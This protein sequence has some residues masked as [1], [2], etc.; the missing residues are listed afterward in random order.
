MKSFR[1]LETLDISRKEFLALCVL[2]S[3][4]FAGILLK[5]FL[6]SHIGSEDIK[7]LRQDPQETRL[8][9]DVNSA[10]WYEL[11][12]LPKIGEKRARAIVEYREKYGPFGSPE[13]L[14]KVKGMSPGVL[15]EIKG[16]LRVD[17]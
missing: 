17:R 16:Y 6:D 14:L 4:L 8:Q 10:G 13:D 7:M 5:Y 2:F 1:V 9:L 11:M 12:A 15:E 3:T